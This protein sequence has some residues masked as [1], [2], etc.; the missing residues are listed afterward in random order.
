MG[1]ELGRGEQVGPA[2]GD[3]G[4]HWRA[5]ANCTKENT[6]AIDD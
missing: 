2:G 4:P 5:A 6:N 3:A 1:R